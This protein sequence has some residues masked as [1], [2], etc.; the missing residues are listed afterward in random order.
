[1]PTMTTASVTTTEVECDRKPANN[2]D[3]HIWGR[4]YI[5][6]TNIRWNHDNDSMSGFR[7]IRRGGLCWNCK[8]YNFRFSYMRLLRNNNPSTHSR[9]SRRYHRFWPIFGIRSK[10]IH[11][12][13]CGY[14][15][16][17]V[18]GNG[19]NPCT[20]RTR[21]GRVRD[22]DE[23]LVN[24]FMGSSFGVHVPCMYTYVVSIQ[25]LTQSKSPCKSQMWY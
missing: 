5:C 19:Q 18:C 15:F 1:M 20:S 22:R 17:S 10:D 9:V 14:V 6:T 11:P 3:I 21:T 23:S 8:S 2:K 25:A 16:L 13:V 7:V 12:A 4:I 24:M